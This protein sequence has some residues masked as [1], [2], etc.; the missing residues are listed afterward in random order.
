LGIQ[1]GGENDDGWKRING[2]GFK[3]LMGIEE[4]TEKKGYSFRRGG[5]IPCNVHKKIN[6]VDILMKDN[7]AGL[8]EK[9]ERLRRRNKEEDE[10]K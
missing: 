2:Q 8:E 6:S 4:G 1:E 10:G 3:R 5:E 7:S 9:R